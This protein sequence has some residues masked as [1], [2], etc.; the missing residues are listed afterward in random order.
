MPRTPVVDQD[1]CIGCEVCTQLCPEVF[2][3]DED[4]N[5]SHGHGHKSRV[6]NPTGASEEKIEIAMDSCP[7]ACIY[8]ED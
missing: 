3:M 6:Y 7:A 4:Q 1:A 5:E 2:K 8:W